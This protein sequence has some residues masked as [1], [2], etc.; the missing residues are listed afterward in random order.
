MYKRQ[1]SSSVSGQI[2]IIPPRK[3]NCP[4]ASACAFFSY[5]IPKS[6]ILQHVEE[7]E[8][9]LDIALH[10]IKEKKLQGLIF[11]GGSFSH[12]KEKMEQLEVPYVLSTIRTAGENCEQYAAVRCV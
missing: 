2:S 11:L 9:E 7:Q 5:P 8:D 12:P 10:I 6:C 1:G 4:G 3:E